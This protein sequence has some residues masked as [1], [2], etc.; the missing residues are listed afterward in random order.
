MARVWLQD[1]STQIVRSKYTTLDVGHSD[2][3]QLKS[4]APGDICNTDILRQLTATNPASWYF[5]PWH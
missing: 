1:G 5:L 3:S 4:N 2:G